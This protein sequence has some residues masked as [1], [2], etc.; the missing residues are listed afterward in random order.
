MRST[1]PTNRSITALAIDPQS[2]STL[3]AGGS[4]AIFKSTDAGTTWTASNTGLPS[5][6]NWMNALLIDPQNPSTVYVGTSGVSLD[7]QCGIPCGGFNDGVFKS[8]DAGAT[9]TAVNSGLTTTHVSSLAIDPQNPNRLYAGTLGGGVFAITFGPAPVVTDFRFNQT[10]IAAGGS[11][12]VTVSGSNLTPQT[13]FD[14]RFSA[15]GSS[16]SDVVLNW[17]QGLVASHEAPAGIAAGTW[18]ITGVRAHELEADHSDSFVP[19]SATITVS[20]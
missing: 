3:Y 17:Q 4:G 10:K 19:V 15:P 14:V 1:S 11:Y 12:S 9:W 7:V 18:T 6:P 16:A 20:H 5:N 8:T 13:F 2:P